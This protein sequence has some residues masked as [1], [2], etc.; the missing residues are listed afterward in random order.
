[1]VDA[2][3]GAAEADA[4]T[5][6]LPR[7][8]L[9]AVLSKLDVRQRAVASRVCRRWRAAALEP[10]HSTELSLV[11]VGDVR[12]GDAREAAEA[13]L[14]F[15][16]ARRPWP[17]SP[18]ADALAALLLELGAMAPRAL[19][20]GEAAALL[21]GPLCAGLARLRL[22]VLLRARAASEAAQVDLSAFCLEDALRAAAPSL[23]HLDLRFPAEMESRLEHVFA[24]LAPAFAER[25]AALRALALR[26]HEGAVHLSSPLEAR[27]PRGAPRGPPAPPPPPLGP[28]PGRRPAPLA[29]LAAAGLRC[30]H[31]RLAAPRGRRADLAAPGAL[32]A[33][34]AL[35]RPYDFPA[36]SGA[37]ALRFEA[38]DLPEDWG[39]PEARL[40]EGAARRARRPAP[41]PAPAPA[42]FL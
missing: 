13:L 16:R 19:S 41:A 32:A 7:E 4:P 26:G 12:E 34:A 30:R 8:L 3:A 11:V 6:A 37:A 28:L 31:L 18:L 24:R 20:V 1:M 42:P 2:G 10:P 25:G 9:S 39:G 15:F 14:A 5:Y 36:D 22:A 17:A 40:F 33:A 35:F 23:R 29:P 27:D 21:A 38:C